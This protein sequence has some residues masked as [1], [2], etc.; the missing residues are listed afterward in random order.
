VWLHATGRTDEALTFADTNAQASP[1]PDRGGRG[2][3]Q[4]RQHVLGL[5]R[6]PRGLLPCG[7]HADGAA[8]SLR[9]RHLALLVHNLSVGG[10]VPEARELADEVRGPIKDSGDVRARIMLELAESGNFCADGRFAQALALIELALIS[11]EHYQAWAL[12]V[13]EAG[14]ARALLQLGLRQASYTAHNI[15]HPVAVAENKAIGAVLNGGH[16]RHAR[17]RG[18]LAAAVLARQVISPASACGA[19][20]AAS[21]R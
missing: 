5:T 9:N 18:W 1:A 10:R 6:D 16:R 4:H 20:G 8:A 13:F 2:P 12:R 19:S 14:R 11:G 7:P 3:A 15:T 21:A 17:R